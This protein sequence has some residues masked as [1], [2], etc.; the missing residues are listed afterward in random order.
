MSTQN[1]KVKANVSKFLE[2]VT[3]R[4]D[5]IERQAEIQRALFEDRSKQAATDLR[6]LTAMTKVNHPDVSSKTVEPHVI[7]VDDAHN[8]AQHYAAAM[9]I[10]E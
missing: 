7:A 8:Q 3:S 2:A 5:S 9:G 6:V 4:M 1:K 10:K